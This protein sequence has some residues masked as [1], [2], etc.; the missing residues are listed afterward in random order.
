MKYSVMIIKIKNDEIMRRIC[1]LLKMDSRFD[2]NVQLF[3]SQK[4]LGRNMKGQWR[5]NSPIQLRKTQKSSS[6]MTKWILLNT[7]DSPLGMRLSNQRWD[8]IVKELSLRS[9][10]LQYICITSEIV[11]LVSSREQEQLLW[12]LIISS[13][14]ARN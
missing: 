5:R 12:L 14:Y 2:L 1:S 8:S 7:I 11:I 6:L 13:R 4:S 10:F 9:I 3:L